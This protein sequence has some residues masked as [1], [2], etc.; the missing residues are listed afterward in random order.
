[1][2]VFTPGSNT[3]RLPAISRSLAGRT[4]S[5]IIPQREN[6]RKGENETY[7]LQTDA[8]AR[9]IVDEKIYRCAFEEKVSSH[10]W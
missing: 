5:S 8:F 2:P 3:Q 1:M 10:E 9:F 4:F 6:E 7:C